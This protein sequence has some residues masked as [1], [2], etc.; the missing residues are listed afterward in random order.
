L[1]SA[2]IGWMRL[3]ALRSLFLLQGANPFLYVVVGKARTLKRRENASLFR[4]CRA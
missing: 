2:D 4:H 3:S 1:R